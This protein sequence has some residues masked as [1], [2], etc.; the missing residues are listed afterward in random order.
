VLTAIGYQFQ[1]KTIQYST[2]LEQ[3]YKWLY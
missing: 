2:H 3:Q 1:T